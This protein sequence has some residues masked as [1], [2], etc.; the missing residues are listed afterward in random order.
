MSIR[1]L[2]FAGLKDRTGIAE[3]ALDAADLDGAAPAGPTV[4]DLLR[5]LVRRWSFLDGFPFA[6]AVNQEFATGER[7]LGDGDVV[8][9]L[10][11]VSGG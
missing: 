2:F 11:P 6:V 4:D 8:A 5:A 10:P 9:L 7:P 3:L 1:V